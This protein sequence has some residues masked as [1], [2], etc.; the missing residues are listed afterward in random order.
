MEHIC[1]CMYIVCV[2]D[3]EDWMAILRKKRRTRGGEV[4]GGHW[5]SVYNQNTMV[6]MYGNVTIKTISHPGSGGTRL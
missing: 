3:W 6:F 5:G 2:C 1:V 4:A